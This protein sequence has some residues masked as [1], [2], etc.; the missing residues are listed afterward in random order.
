MKPK[1][2]YEARLKRNITRKVYGSR[3]TYKKGTVIWNCT[4]KQFEKLTSNNIRD[5]T[6]LSV[7]EG[8]GYYEYFDLEKDIEFVKVQIITN[9][10]ESIVQLNLPSD[11][12][13]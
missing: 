3:K 5:Q 12:V 6:N 9:V 4:E 11:L 7:C 13:K 1:T 8:H 10:R 2:H